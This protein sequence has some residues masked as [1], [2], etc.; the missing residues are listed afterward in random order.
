M[1][2]SH[3][4]TESLCSHLLKFPLCRS[5]HHPVKNPKPEFS[6]TLPCLSRRPS[7]SL[8]VTP[9]AHSA[10]P[11]SHY[12]LQPSISSILHSFLTPTTHTHTNTKCLLSSCCPCCLLSHSSSPSCQLLA[13]GAGATTRPGLLCL[14]Y[15]CV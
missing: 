9:S 12:P 1:G 10:F 2:T 8:V 14:L 4:N 3:N 15:T 11:K 5:S 6:P 7:A 13:L